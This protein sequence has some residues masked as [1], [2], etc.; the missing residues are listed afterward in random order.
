M[1]VSSVHRYI[2]RNRMQNPII[3][4]YY[5]YAKVFGRNGY[6]FQRR[7]LRVVYVFRGV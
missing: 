1:K 4:L 6:I 5:V 7:R 3:K 2:T